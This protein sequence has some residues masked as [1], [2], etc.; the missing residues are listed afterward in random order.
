MLHFK[1]VYERR[2]HRVYAGFVALSFYKCL[3]RD[4][5]IAFYH[6]HLGIARGDIKKNFKQLTLDC[7]TYAAEGMGSLTQ[8]GQRSGGLTINSDQQRSGNLRAGSA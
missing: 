8:T 6:I 2:K 3:K 7:V 5:I 4:Y 1:N